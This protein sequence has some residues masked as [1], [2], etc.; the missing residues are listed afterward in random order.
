[1]SWSG[2]VSDHTGNF[3]DNKFFRRLIGTRYLGKMGAAFKRTLLQQRSG[4]VTIRKGSNL[5]LK[6]VKIYGHFFHE[7][8]G[9][10]L[11]LYCR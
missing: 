2:T 6:N 4:Y 8:N 7:L 1:M 10:R 11:S 5:H 9:L 3:K